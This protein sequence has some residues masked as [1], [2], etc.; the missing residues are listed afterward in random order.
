MKAETFRR[1]ESLFGL[2]P[3]FLKR[4]EDAGTVLDWA[5][6]FGRRSGEGPPEKRASTAAP[7]G[8]VICR[9]GPNEVHSPANTDGRDRESRPPLGD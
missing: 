3:S 7:G 4:L 8:R 2:V 5:A 6:P 9:Y 1:I